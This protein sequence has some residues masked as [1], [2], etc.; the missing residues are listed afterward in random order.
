MNVSDALKLYEN[1][2][3][4][5]SDFCVNDNEFFDYVAP[6]SLHSG[7]TTWAYGT[8]LK[9]RCIR[10]SDKEYL[11]SIVNIP[12]VNKRFWIK[13]IGCLEEWQ[14]SIND[15]TIR[16]NGKILYHCDKELFENVNLG[17]PAIYYY[18]SGEYFINGENEITVSTQNSSNA[19]LLI[20]IIDV[21]ALPEIKPFSQIS[22]LDFAKKGV[23]YSIAF[24]AVKES[25]SKIEKEKNCD[26]ISCEYFNDDICIL[27]LKSSDEGMASCKVI[28]NEKSIEANLPVIVTNDDFCLVGIDSDDHRHDISDEANRILEIFEMTSMGNYFQFRP[29]CP[30]N[31]YSLAP[32]SIWEKRVKFLKSFNTRIGLT[33]FGNVISFIPEL[34]GENY[35]LSH[36]HEP[37]LFYNLKLEQYDFIRENYLHNS[38]A[39][40]AC[41]SFA[42]SEKLFR[43]VL[44]KRKD[45]LVTG[46]EVFSVGSPSL[47]CVY[48]GDV[49]FDRV[50]IEPVSNINILTGAVRVVNAEMWGSHIP[51][52]WYYG[53]PN[54]DCK[55]RKFRLAM[56]YLYINGASYIYPENAC[57][58][59]N[60][61]SREDWE[62]EFCRENRKYLREFYSYTVKNPR[63]GKLMVDKAVIYGRHEHFLWHYDDRIAELDEKGDWDTKVWGKWS[64]EYRKC[65]RAIDAW[66]PL[67]EHQNIQESPLNKKLFSG[68]PYGNVDVVSYNKDWSKYNTIAFLGW[69]TM[70]DELICKLKDYVKN[71]GV[72]II[73]YCHFNETDRNDWEM[74]FPESKFIED[75][76]GVTICGDFIPKGKVI[77]NDKKEIQIDSDI[78]S[79]L[80]EPISAS[81]VANDENGIG[82]IFENKFGEG[83][84]YFSVFKE[85]FS[86]QWSV[87]VMGKLLADIGENG[88]TK[89]DNPN[90]SFTQRLLPNGYIAVDLINMNC[91][92]K[93]GEESFNMKIKETELNGVVKEGEILHV[94]ID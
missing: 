82:I 27:H 93:D 11:K 88:S 61:F 90:I 34:A 87:E 44:Q 68:T 18:V 46:Q 70:N 43:D 31:Y 48:E 79:V 36:I 54:D 45:R 51:V 40:L 64:D 86:K 89:C 16:I 59:T 22:S 91:A 52:D 67:S 23:S 5:K 77:F 63:N 53:S 81:K 37:Y 28:F 32:I 41:E 2:S 84:I 6:S 49:G 26:F 8:A 42:E 57:F 47:L 80:C 12:S 50:S 72:A 3:I 30:R 78:N 69:N 19:G 35:F 38:K 39:V 75:L 9:R 25:F 17:W 33:D 71:G 85:Y 13:I 76:L 21:I 56:N 24:S 7:I 92:I 66:L 94:V 20:S 29:Q 73:S 15:I 83:T 60:A 62:S 14:T 74:T 65:W 1:F 55:S 58:K 10:I 4:Y